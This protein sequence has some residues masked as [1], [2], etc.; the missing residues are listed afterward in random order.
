MQCTYNLNSVKNNIVQ[1]D[2]VF[3]FSLILFIIIIII[4]IIIM[5]H[6]YIYITY[7]L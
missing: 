3:P 5:L 7:Y 4:I 2:N 1:V 6:I